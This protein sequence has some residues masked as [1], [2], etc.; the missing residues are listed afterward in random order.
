MTLIRELVDS[1]RYGQWSAGW[2]TR[3]TW[4]GK[5]YWGL[6]TDYYDGRHW[7]LHLGPLYIGAGY[8]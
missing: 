1:I 6:A 8:Y 5:P 4:P 3:A 7:C 2:A